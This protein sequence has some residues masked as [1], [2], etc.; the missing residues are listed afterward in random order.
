MFLKHGLF[1]KERVE[2]QPLSEE[3]CIQYALDIDTIVRK[4]VSEY[5]INPAEIENQ[6]RLGLLPLLF[7]DLGIDKAQTLITDVIQITRL[8]LAGHH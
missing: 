4:A 5:S 7:N 2:P 8:G 3:Q 6:I 1:L